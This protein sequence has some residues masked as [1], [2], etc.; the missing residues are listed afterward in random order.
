MTNRNF[1]R[2]RQSQVPTLLALPTV[3]GNQAAVRQG[4]EW[5]T[6]LIETTCRC[7]LGQ[8]YDIRVHLKKNH[9]DSLT[10]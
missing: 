9:K 4:A 7:Q 2:K 6:T 5:G 3:W 1:S 8:R 10:L